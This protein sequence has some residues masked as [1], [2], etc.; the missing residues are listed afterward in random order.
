MPSGLAGRADL[1]RVHARF[2]PFRPGATLGRLAAGAFAGMVGGLAM[3][4]VYV[5]FHREEVK[6]ALAAADPRWVAWERGEAR[7]LLG[8]AR[9]D[10]I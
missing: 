5:A 9:T 4:L 6:E 2:D 3:G 7:A 1:P 10:W 8:A